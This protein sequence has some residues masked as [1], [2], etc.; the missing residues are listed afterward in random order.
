MKTRL[1]CVILCLVM[2][3][4]FA[5]CGKKSAYP[6]GHDEFKAIIGETKADALKQLK[7]QESDLTELAPFVYQ[8]PGNYSFCD[9]TFQSALMLDAVAD[10]IYGFIYYVPVDDL[11]GLVP[12]R[13]KLIELFGQPNDYVFTQEDIEKGK[14]GESIGIGN[15][16]SIH[17]FTREHHPEY[18]EYIE[19]YM[20]KSPSKCGYAWGLSMELRHSDQGQRYV[21]LTFQ[22][23]PDL[24][25]PWEPGQDR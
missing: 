25:Q 19:A 9:Y 20:E 4:S 11:S 14:N 16:W 8:V 23:G 22:V 24:S 12:M 13:D 6:E 18:A 21:V 10:R 2:I 3:L 7:L 5:G 17:S 1:I 15:T